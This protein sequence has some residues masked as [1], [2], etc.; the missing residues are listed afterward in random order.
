VRER[1]RTVPCDLRA[2]PLGERGHAG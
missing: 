1:D 2:N